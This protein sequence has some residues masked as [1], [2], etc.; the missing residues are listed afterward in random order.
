MLLGISVDGCKGIGDALQFSSVPENY[1][2]ATGRHLIDVSNAWFFDHNPY[3]V[4]NVH[5]KKT[6]QMWNFGPQKY[7]WP[8]PRPEGSPRVYLSNAEIHAAVWGVEARLIRPRLYKHED[9]PFENRK[10]ILLHTDGKSHGDMPRHV[11]QHVIDKYHRTGELYLIGKSNENWGIPRIETP[12]LWD[13]ARVISESRMLIG[14]DSS[15]AWI[16]ACYPDVVVKKLKNRM[17]QRN[18][19]DWIPL[20]IDN[21]H[22]HWDDRCHM[23]FNPTEE[24]IGFAESYRNI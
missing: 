8:N 6:I 11:V 9:F 19:R 4:R 3:I 15:P 5:S 12:T 20:E 10:R 16:A 2:R 7:E 21:H 13:L 18:L 1:F 22:A 24:A 14:M 23:I 17:L